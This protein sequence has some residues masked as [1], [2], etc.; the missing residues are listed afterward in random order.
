ML[1]RASPK[2]NDKCPHKR[3]TEERLREKRKG[4]VKT[5]AEIRVM[6]PQALE[7]LGP[8]EAGRVRTKLS[9]EPPGGA[10]PC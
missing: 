3:L 10:R 9:L 7:L 2:S 6:L 1:F 5:E 8:P 4:H